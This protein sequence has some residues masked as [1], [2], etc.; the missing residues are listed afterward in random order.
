[1]NLQISSSKGIQLLFQ[2]D[3]FCLALIAWLQECCFINF[4][5]KS[6]VNPFSK[7]RNFTADQVKLKGKTVAFL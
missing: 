5:E 4:T 7:V 3:K 2:V 1:M 6:C